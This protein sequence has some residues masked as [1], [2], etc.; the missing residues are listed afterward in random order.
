MDIHGPA[1]P[2]SILSPRFRIHD[3]ETA[4]PPQISRHQRNHYGAI[5]TY[6]VA[7]LSTLSTNRDLAN[8]LLLLPVCSSTR[9]NTDNRYI[10]ASF[11]PPISVRL[12]PALENILYGANI[13]NILARHTNPVLDVLGW[14]PYGV[15]HFGAPLACS[16][17][18]FIFGPP[19]AVPVFA[20]SFG[21][22]NIIGVII[23]ILFPCSPP[24]Y[25]NLYGLAPAHY[26][27]PGSPGG[28]ARIDLLFGGDA[29]TSSFTASPMVFG[30]FP[31]LHSGSATMEAMFLAYCFPKVRPFVYAY[32]LWIWWATMYLTHHYFVD[33]IG[34]SILAASC[35]YYAQRNYMP[36]IQP[37]K[38]LRWDYEYIIRGESQDTIPNKNEFTRVPVIDTDLELGTD[39]EWALGSSSSLSSGNTTPVTETS[40]GWNSDSTR[41]GARDDEIEEA[42]RQLPSPRSPQKHHK[43]KIPKQALA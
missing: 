38:Q 37:G 12:L 26:G 25:E 33:L 3:S 4:F 1:S 15:I 27:M 2:V 30:A 29:Y 28:L 9:L 13:S 42:I 34:G 7:V 32:V 40:I 8:I 23:Q 31:S 35:F 41:A 14:L 17:V 11:R 24:W 43:F 39:T 19:E 36:Q 21:Y 22:M 16:I 5:N 6:Y 20:M 18:M 10:P